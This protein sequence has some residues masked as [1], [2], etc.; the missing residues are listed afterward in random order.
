L[1]SIQI[2]DVFGKMIWNTNTVKN[3]SGINFSKYEN[4]VYFVKLNTKTG[5]AQ[6][7][8]IIKQ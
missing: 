7:H 4:G 5:K 2:Y 1:K 3:I 6:T 8:K